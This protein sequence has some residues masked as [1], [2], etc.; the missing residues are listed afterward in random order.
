MLLGH[1][2]YHT[3]RFAAE[4]RSLFHGNWACDN[5]CDNARTIRGV[6]RR[7]DDRAPAQTLDKPSLNPGGGGHSFCS[8][9]PQTNISYAAARSRISVKTATS[10]S[11]CTDENTPSGPLGFTSVNGDS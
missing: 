4:N 11:T 9:R 2:P 8:G 3:T 5:E 10:W 1:A 6:T 7:R